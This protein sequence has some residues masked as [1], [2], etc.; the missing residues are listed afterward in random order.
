[1]AQ[2]QY[3]LRESSNS[4]CKLR[5]ALGHEYYTGMEVR[6]V[7][8]AWTVGDALVAGRVPFREDRHWNSWVVY[9]NGEDV[10]HLDSLETLLGTEDVITLM[11]YSH[12]IRSAPR[13]LDDSQN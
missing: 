8:D 2:A 9:L 10:R 7:E 11:P 4:M 5:I 3:P 13:Y 6:R 1:M 12:T